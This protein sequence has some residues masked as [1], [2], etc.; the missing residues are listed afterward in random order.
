M[1]PFSTKKI[2]LLF[3]GFLL[4]NTLLFGQ[5]KTITGKVTG[6][7]GEPLI[8]VNVIIKGTT[9]G[10][11][12]NLDGDYSVAV[13]QGATLVFS[14]IG[15][16]DEEVI[17]S[18]QT[19]VNI[20]LVEDLHKLEEVVVTALG[21]KKEKKA[22]GYAF[23]D[24]D[25]DELT[26]NRDANFINSLSNKVAGVNITQTAGGAGTSSRIVIR[27]IKSLSTESQ[28]L[29]VIDG[30]PMENNS[31][32]VSWSS[33]SS[34]EYGNNLGSL[35]PDD[36]ESMSVLK[37]P[38]AAA[39][40]G[41]EAANGVIIITTK[42][43]TKSDKLRVTF[44][45]N[46]MMDYAYIHG[47]YQ[48]K[49]GVGSGGA[50]WK[51]ELSQDQKDY[52]FEEYGVV[53]DSARFANGSGSW[54]PSLTDWPYEDTVINWNG[55]LL[56]QL[57]PHPDN[58]EYYFQPGYTFTNTL[59]LEK[60][61][62]KF[63][64]RFSIAQL[65]NEGLKPA[66]T[67]KRKNV[68]YAMNSEMNK[69]LD[70]SLNASYIR[71]DAH[72]RV[73]M[74]NS[75]SGA[76]TFIYMPR[77]V[78][79]RVLERDYK[80]ENGNELNYGYDSGVLL[81]NPYWEA[82]ENYNNDHKDQFTSL[83]KVNV[84]ITPWLSGFVRSSI[85]MYSTKRYQR[86]ANGSLKDPEGGFSEVYKNYRALNHDFL[87][88]ANKSFGED[89]SF[90]FNVGGRINEWGVDYNYNTAY[91]L[92]IPNFFSINNY[93]NEIRTTSTKA[94]AANHSLYGSAQMNY[95][96]W[97]FL[98]L[99]YRQD[100]NSTLPKGEWSYPYPSV[101]TSLVF[102]D[103]LG[104]ENQYFTFG[105]V[106][107][108]YAVVGNGTAPYNLYT[109]FNSQPYGDYP[110]NYL[111]ATGLN[112]NLIPEQTRSWE[113]GADLKFFGNRLGIDA[114]YY[115]EVTANQIYRAEVSK[116]GGYARQLLNGGEIS[117]KGVEL[118]LYFSPVRT[119]NFDWDV[120]VNYAMNR[121]KVLSLAEGITE[122]Q[123]GGDSQV[124]VVAKPGLPYGEMIG[125]TI[126][127]F[128]SAGHTNHGKYLVSDDGTFLKGGLGS[129]GNITPDFIGG[130]N[131]NLRYKNFSLGF[132]IGF[133]VGGDIFSKT[134]KYGRDK[135]VFEETL[136]GRESW[137]NAT[138]DERN[139]F[140]REGRYNA[141]G[142]PM[143]DNDGNQLFDETSPHIG[144]LA[145]GVT[146]NGE[147]NTKGIDPQVYWHQ[148]KWGGIAEL[149]IYD[150][151]YVKLRDITLTYNIPPKLLNRVFI[152]TGSIS[153]VAKNVWLIYSGA[154]NIDPEASFGATNVALGQEYASMPPTRSYGFNLKLVF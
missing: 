120:N 20:T 22:L 137:Y 108:S 11:V 114:T 86:I 67:Y 31:N 1:K 131:N 37:G 52:Y 35:N 110:T 13:P 150:A 129:V 128:D 34:L 63:N 10:T 28:P 15:Y 9:E 40:Y 141:D 12:T 21:I 122:L 58:V 95:K 144:M 77:N 29:I 105:K 16:L 140:G 39:L 119:S 70:F 84:K 76:K 51:Q 101:N 38:N 62:K 87:I 45:S 48:N 107:F 112:P 113:V 121:N 27:G 75:T 83:A 49:Y 151:S 94:K 23:T 109:T 79:T 32:D 134:N 43:G 138:D 142:S 132:T 99:T 53:L 18:D 91:G 68:S 44:N 56:T 135:G 143:L 69:F 2:L 57:S 25:G 97:Y 7:D 146:A 60:G 17:I 123:I 147:T 92:A 14:F 3:A 149:D 104:I 54:G 124:K 81:F 50:L 65:D 61:T 19:V 154:P 4:L 103:A 148:F 125:E 139:K 80:D 30:V 145:H 36:I 153:F 47:K 152:N 93:K 73:G 130:I 89:F 59:S 117:N 96:S 8:G 6:S 88:T 74:S 5:E 55:D 127:R 90:N 118:Q 111:P 72:N 46:F 71:E 116:A 26:T 100:W 115:E 42:K 24:V 41:S 102:S 33:S 136:E 133:Q 82:Y 126:A 85:N 64:W 98:E 66:S 78:D 106:R